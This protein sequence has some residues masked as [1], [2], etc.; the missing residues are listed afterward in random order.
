MQRSSS[1]ASRSH[2]RVSGS[3]RSAAPSA[4]ST[5]AARRRC[6]LTALRAVAASGLARR[7]PMPRLLAAAPAEGALLLDYLPGAPVADWS[8]AVLDEVAGI[9]DAVHRLELD[10]VPAWGPQRD[11]AKLDRL[12]GLLEAA[13]AG[14]AAAV[15]PAAA[16][17]AERPPR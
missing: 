7:V 4:R 14:A 13:D 17:L 16:A 1:P 11:V 2:R 12:V 9:L 3:P 5:P 10:A 15:R 8:A 6:S